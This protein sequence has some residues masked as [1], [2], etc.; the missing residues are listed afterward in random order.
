MLKGTIIG[1][2]VNPI[3]GVLL[4]ILRPDVGLDLFFNTPDNPGKFSRGTRVLFSVSAVGS[5]DYSG[6]AQ[7][8]VNVTAM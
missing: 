6:G 4:G 8:A 7:I 1:F 2:Q 3:T 5:P